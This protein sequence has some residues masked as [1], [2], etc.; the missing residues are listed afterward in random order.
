M[1]SIM[2]KNCGKKYSYQTSQFLKEYRCFFCNALN[3]PYK[4]K[5]KN[6]RLEELE[7]ERELEFLN[8]KISGYNSKDD[9]WRAEKL[10]KM[11]DYE[12]WDLVKKISRHHHPKGSEDLYMDAI[13][14]LNKN[15]MDI[16]N[17]KENCFIINF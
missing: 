15:Q 3:L 2:C 10:Q 12:L 7:L 11:Q 6:K 4:P 1:P 5:N 17:I 9:K 8:N 13:K 14:Q 16:N